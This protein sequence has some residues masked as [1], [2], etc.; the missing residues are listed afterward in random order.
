MSSQE[1]PNTE[2]NTHVQATPVSS[3]P[4]EPRTASRPVTSMLLPLAGW[5]LLLGGL[6]ITVGPKYVTELG[7]YAKQIARSGFSGEIMCLGGLVMIGLGWIASY[8]RGFT[9]TLLQPGMAESLIEDL[10]TEVVA[11]QDLIRNLGGTQVEQG[12]DLRYLKKALG[13][14]RNETRAADPK[15]AIFRLAASLDQLGARLDQ[16]I[17]EATSVL[18]DANYELSSM[19]ESS[20]EGIQERMEQNFR[21]LSDEVRKTISKMGL[22]E[23]ESFDEGLEGAPSEG[24]RV[25]VDLDEDQAEEAEAAKEARDLGLLNDLGDAERTSPHQPSLFKDSANDSPS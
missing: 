23:S 24:L 17:G 6:A 13:E 18:Q 3:P 16:R 20:C 21:T 25:L 9:H 1:S 10:Q 15:D 11:A 19:V 12:V 7:W 2:P 14:A 5:L 8:Q 22:V 4:L